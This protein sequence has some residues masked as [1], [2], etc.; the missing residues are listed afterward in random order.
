MVKSQKS[1]LCVHWQS[2]SSPNWSDTATTGGFFLSVVNSKWG[3]PSTPLRISFFGQPLMS[4]P[5]NSYLKWK[6]TMLP[7]PFLFMFSQ[8]PRENCIRIEAWLPSLKAVFMLYDC[9]VRLLYGS[10]INTFLL[11]V[12]FYLFSTKTLDTKVRL[13]GL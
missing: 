12:L 2:P 11:I 4:H 13:T 10:V 9:M 5:V 1:I 6:Y 7:W 3:C 8:T